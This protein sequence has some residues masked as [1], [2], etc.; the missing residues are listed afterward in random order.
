MPMSSSDANGRRL[1]LI[2]QLLRLPEGQ[3]PAVEQFLGALAAGTPSREALPTPIAAPRDWPHAPLHRLCD[4]GTY[5]VT[6]GTYLKAHHFAAPERREQLEA[7]LLSLAKGAGWQLEAWAVFSNHYHL[8]GH[9]Q[10]GCEPL[11]DWLARLHH[12]AAVHVNDLD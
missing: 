12:Q 6:A 11:A 1:R 5:L 2:E 10:A 7:D 3:L 9:A 8:V 4:H